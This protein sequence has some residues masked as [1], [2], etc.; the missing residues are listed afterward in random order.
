MMKGKK[1]KRIAISLW[2]TL[3]VAFILMVAGGC[4]DS[5]EEVGSYFPVDNDL[6]GDVY[7]LNFEDESYE[8]LVAQQGYVYDNSFVYSGEDP[9]GSYE[10][11]SDGSFDMVIETSGSDILL[12]GKLTSDTEGTLVYSDGPETKKGTIQSADVSTLQ[13]VWRCILTENESS[14]TYSMVLSVES[15]GAIFPYENEPL[16]I[17]GYSRMVCLSDAVIGSFIKDS[18]NGG[19]FPYDALRFYGTLSDNIVTG[20]YDNYGNNKTGTVEFEMIVKSDYKE[21]CE[22]LSAT[23][24]TSMGLIVVDLYVNERP[25]TVWNFVNLAEGRQKTIKEDGPFYDGLIFHRVIDG[26][27]IQGGCPYGDGTGGPGY[28]F[29]DEF[30]PPLDHGHDSEGVLSMANSGQDTNG[31]QFFITLGAASH[32]D[33]VHTIFG[34]VTGGINVVRDIGSV[35]TDDNDKP[36]DDDV[37]INSI[38]VDHSQCDSGS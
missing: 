26:F 7:I 20:A 14:D 28:T 33:G 12:K 24:N 32:L 1:I 11:L 34:R 19:S 25:E 17:G 10:A 15:W 2:M 30:D 29:N 5:L 9:A 27:M 37:V 13:G 16:P 23:I 31:S 22:S 3:A 18:E 6:L 38:T 21:E 4:S 8:Y 36:K 35:P